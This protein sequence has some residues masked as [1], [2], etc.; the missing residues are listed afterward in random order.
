M[1]IKHSPVG[2]LFIYKGQ[3]IGSTLLQGHFVR[4]LSHDAVKNYLTVFS[5]DIMGKAQIAST[6]CIPQEDLCSTPY[7]D[8]EAIMNFKVGEEVKIT[9]EAVDGEDGWLNGW[10]T[11]MDQSV[12]RTGHIFKVPITDDSGP[13][14]GIPGE[15]VFHFPYFC[16]ERVATEVEEPEEKQ[17]EEKPECINCKKY[18]LMN[19]ICTKGEAGP[20][21]ECF[22]SVK[23]S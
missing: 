5:K 14:V 23:K 22:I 20:S 16:L 8:A 19:F 3:G 15:P 4:C 13:M 18:S 7:P 9:R 12:G 1:L 17:E 2:K 6:F 10:I 21:K 11:K